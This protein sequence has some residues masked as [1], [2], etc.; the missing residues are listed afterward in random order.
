M[1][2]YYADLGLQPG[3]SQEEIKKAFRTLAAQYH[4]DKETGDEEKF[5]QINTAYG[6]LSGKAQPPRQSQRNANYDPFAHMH[7]YFNDMN[8]QYAGRWQRR[9]PPE[10]DREVGVE[11]SVSIEDIK[12]GKEATLKYQKSK[13]CED[14]NG[15]GGKEKETCKDCQGKGVVRKTHVG[16]NVT[17][18]TDF[19]CPTC[20]GRGESIKESC[21]V[22]NSQG[23]VVYSEEL[24]VEIK[25]KKQ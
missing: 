5:K 19:P 4:P 17:F 15:I 16:D 21:S 6:I 20:Q 22:C 23:F 11:L 1:S 2:D 10:H 25:E 7:A 13:L 3:A 9:K 12:N 18:S 24:T 14:C 8:R